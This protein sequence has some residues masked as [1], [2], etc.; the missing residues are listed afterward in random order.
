MPWGWVVRVSLTSALLKSLFEIEILYSYIG[1]YSWSHGVWQAYTCTVKSCS[2]TKK[3]PPPNLPPPTPP[4]S[5]GLLYPWPM[6]HSGGPVKVNSDI[7]QQKCG[8]TTQR[9]V[10]TVTATKKSPNTWTIMIK[11]AKWLPSLICKTT[12]FVIQTRGVFTWDNSHRHEFH[13]DMTFWFRIAFTWWLGYFTSRYLK[14]HFMLIKCTYDSKSRTLHMGYPFQSTGRP[15]SP[16]RV[17][18][19]CLHDTVA[20]FRT[21]V[22][23]LPR[24]KNRGELVPGWLAPAW[25][26]WWY[27]GNKYRAMRGNR[28]ELAPGRKSP[29]GHVNTP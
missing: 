27:H 24:Y 21:R 20:R 3:V 5:P 22:K 26:L 18:V 12:G 7:G 29:R 11:T 14:I 1:S 16:K 2:P 25:N 15:I 4:P 10:E 9:W 13:T 6:A 17:V 19:S 8:E 28:S 23:F